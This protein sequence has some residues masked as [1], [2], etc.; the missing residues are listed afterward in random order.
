MMGA[1]T[2]VV[3][4][5]A[6]FIGSAVARA[7]LARGGRVVGI[8]NFD[9]FYARVVKERNVAGVAAAA[10]SRADWEMTE[11]DLADGAA[12]RE[13]FERVRP[14]GVIHLGAKAGVRPSI[15]DPAGYMRANVMGTQSVLS[16]A[17]ATGVER[18]VQA[19]SSSVYGNAS[20]VPF[21]E[22]DEATAPISPYAA[23][24]R[25]CELLAHT[26]H[27]LTGMPTASLRFFTVYGPGQRPDLAIGLFMRKIARGEPIEMFGDGS[28]SRDFTFIED[29]VAGVLAALERVDGHGC[30]VWN[31]GNSSPVRLD[32]M[33][34]TIER[35][36][37]KGAKVVRKPMQAGD[38][39][40]TFADLERSRAE[41]GYSPA[42][43]FEEGVRR[44]WEWMRE[45]GEGVY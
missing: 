12:V 16:A 4:G 23:S 38:V 28:M 7:I 34:A 2:T 35:V 31:L 37:G 25:A 40:R 30:R 33:I 22:S 26:H 15:T 32:E 20:K 17:A 9:P 44:Q 11:V 14:Q 19:S 43:K 3:T 45:S 41:L 1:G 10:K 27:H 18:V 29:I 21:S 36:V 39:E 6:G 8:D 13:V 5:A 24:K 42:T